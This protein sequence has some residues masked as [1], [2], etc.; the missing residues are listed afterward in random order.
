MASPTAVE[1]G[2]SGGGGEDALREQ[3]AQLLGSVDQLHRAL[4]V[5]PNL[6]LQAPSRCGAALC[7]R[8]A[9]PSPQPAPDWQGGVR[10]TLRAT[11]RHALL[12]AL[13]APAN[14]PQDERY[15]SSALEERLQE[16]QVQ[17]R[18]LADENEQLSAA[19]AG[20]A[21]ELERELAHA[22]AEVRACGWGDFRA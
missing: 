17:L 18:A 3:V 4:Q 8:P 19:A 13:F 7:G 14:V 10:S 12:M 9:P 20:G 11:S 16:Q 21:P 6:L 2:G 22:R 15:N 1:P 5:G